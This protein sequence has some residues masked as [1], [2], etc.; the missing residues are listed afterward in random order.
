MTDLTGKIALVTGGARNVGKA[1]ARELAEQGALVIVN[2]FHALDAAKETRA[3]FE[4]LGLKVELMR[5]SV[6][7]PAQLE[8]MFAD[9][10]ARFGGLDILVNNA[11]SGALLPIDQLTDEHFDR[12]WNTNFKGSFWCSRLAVPLMAR[13]G[14]GSIVNVSALGGSQLV[15][16][17]YLA[18]GPAK[19]AVEA[20]TRYLAVEYAALNVRVN[21][22][23]AAMLVSEVADSFPRAAEMQQVVAASTPL[24]R[25]GTPDDFARVVAFLASDN[26]KWITGQ[27]VLADGGLSLG[28]A[29]LSPPALSA[30]PVDAEQGPALALEEDP[31]GED[32]AVVGMGL[33]VPGANDMESFWRVLSEGA[34]LVVNVPPDRWDHATISSPDWSAEDKTYQSA[35]FFIQDFVTSEA[36]AADAPPDGYELTTLWL[37]H[38]LVQ[39]LEGVRRRDDDRF[40]FVVGYTADGSQHLEEASVLAG[41]IDKA[42]NALAECGAGDA[43][44]RQLLDEITRTLRG[45]YWRGAA[46]SHSR[47][48]MAYPRRGRSAHLTATAME[49]CS[50][51]APAWSS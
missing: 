40:A 51:T 49:C 20:L 41:L 4:R 26:S 50:P 35:S 28:S 30:A 48:C 10:E 11:A 23:S 15:M 31:D 14:G 38:S 17:N 42:G 18:C 1:I 46:P 43:E 22:A 2:F 39:A 32:I 29:L 13:R 19:A 33:A 3:E 25:L 27:V 5:A 16:A 47:S 9:I 8:R 21:T 6:A 44:Q 7:Q 24:G 12:A 34:D 37:R 36:A 45:R